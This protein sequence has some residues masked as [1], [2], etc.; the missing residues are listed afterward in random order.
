MVSSSAAAAHQLRLTQALRQIN[1]PLPAS[2]EE[3][4][5]KEFQT[6]ATLRRRSRGLPRASSHFKT[7]S[8]V[9]RKA[10]PLPVVAGTVDSPQQNTQGRHESGRAAHFGSQPHCAARFQSVEGN[11]SPRPTQARKMIG[12]EPTQR[13]AKPV[14]RRGFSS[15]SA[16][17]N[18]CGNEAGGTPLESLQDFREL[19]FDRGAGGDRLP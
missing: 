11:P 3:I 2:V 18:G 14:G 19:G 16:G 9:R 12:E 6:L 10:S 4:V 13:G 5:P 17:V 1:P 8:F 15:A 7:H